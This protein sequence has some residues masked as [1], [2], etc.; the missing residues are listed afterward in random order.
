MVLFVGLYGLQFLVFCNIDILLIYR[1]NYVVF[2]LAKH[3]HHQ[4]ELA[5]LHGYCL[6][7]SL[8]ITYI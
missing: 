6:M 7:F 1:F 8:K 2:W 4:N 3:H 5:G